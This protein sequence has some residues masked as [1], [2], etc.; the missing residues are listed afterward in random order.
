MIVRSGF[1]VPEHLRGGIASIAEPGSQPAHVLA[2]DGVVVIGDMR[3]EARFSPAPTLLAEGVRSGITAAIPGVRGP[4]GT[5]GAWSRELRD[6]SPDEISLFA[7]LTNGL[8]LAASRARLARRLE[9]QRA[10]SEALAMSETMSEAAPRFLEAICGSLGWAAGIL[11]LV[12]P[13]AEQ[14]RAVDVWLDAAS[15]ERERAFAANELERTT[16]A[17]GERLPGRAWEAG[18][19]QWVSEIPTDSTHTKVKPVL[20]A[21]LRSVL[22]FPIKRGERVLGVVE[23][24]GRDITEPDQELLEDCE[25]FGRKVGEFIAREQAQAQVRA[26]RDELQLVLQHMPVGVTVV[27]P[28]GRY[29]FVN[30]VTARINNA[31]AEELIGVSAIDAIAG[32]TILDEE[33]NELER[34]EL[35]LFRALRG[36]E[37]PSRLVQFTG[38]AVSEQSWAIAH[39]IRLPGPPEAQGA[40]ISVVENV[41]DVKN[42]EALL[43]AS[44][45][46]YREIS[47]TLQRGLLPPDAGEIAGLDFDARLHTEEAGTRI[48]GDFYDVFQVSGDRYAIV[49]GDVSGKGVGAAGLTALARHTIRT[50]AMS[51]PR[52]SGVLRTLNEALL[53]SGADDQYL[54][55][56]YA[57]VE[58]VAD[59]HEV[60]V[61]A[62]GHPPPLKVSADGEVSQVDAHGTLL[63]FFEELELFEGGTRLAPDE[64]MVLFTDGI[65]EAG[66]RDES[67][68][69][70]VTDEALREL[71][72]NCG[73]LSATEIADTIE[74]RV[75]AA[76][77]GELRDD[78]TMVV[79]ASRTR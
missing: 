53:R 75:L 50:A 4:I 33:G 51:D 65:T 29:R 1:A 15:G 36:E 12:Q 72:S 59:G 16:F 10:A 66:F 42:A 20:D 49:I 54:T 45:A 26:S 71:L 43:R 24:L 8:G 47:D 21:G 14:M 52:P 41:T 64:S 63:G 40:V 78:A 23:V 46:R 28:D 62:G 25:R 32:L 55:A 39:A 18:E 34:E 67:P 79:V 76:E 3:S 13:G 37:S 77:G 69:T 73:G 57:L 2:A 22:A 74:A 31:T 61:A 9:T 27:D 38:P 30:D 19:P 68:G 48:G 5:F 44:E 60:R 56:L 17:I 11:W 7:L 35:P 6:F 58:P 70:P